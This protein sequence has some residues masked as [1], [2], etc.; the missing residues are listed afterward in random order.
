MQKC[1]CPGDV[2]IQCHVKASMGFEVCQSGAGPFGE[3]ISA[4]GIGSDVDKT[5]AKPKTGK[6]GLVRSKV[7]FRLEM[8]LGFG[9]MRGCCLSCLAV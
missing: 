8:T 2:E 3:R 4:S 7:T 5:S 1:S 6:S 9:V